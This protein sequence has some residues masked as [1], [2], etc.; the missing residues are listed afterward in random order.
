VITEIT[1]EKGI[2]RWL[3]MWAIATALFA[4]AKWLTCRDALRHRPVSS[5]RILGYLFLWPGMDAAAFFSPAGPIPS[6][7]PREYLAPTLRMVFGAA[8]VGLGAGTVNAGHPLLS[9]W[10][11]MLGL[12]CLLHFGSFHLLALLWRRAGVPAEP[13]MRS[14]SKSASLAE[15]WGVRW[16]RGFHDLVRQHLFVPLRPKLGAPGATFAT[17]FASGILHELVISIPRPAAATVCPP[18]TSSSRAPAC[19]SSAA[20]GALVADSGAARAP[21]S[22]P[23]PPPPGR[24]SGSSLRFLCAASS[25]L[26]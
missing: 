20:R 21:A 12:I 11:G 1:E 10:L 25:S 5:P 3:L 8:L 14:P 22:L 16:N 4:A 7:A 23:S 18:P 15:F 2:E 13:L 6:P 9:G 19:S 26:F 24:S 17:F